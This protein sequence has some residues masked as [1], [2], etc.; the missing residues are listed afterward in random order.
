MRCLAQIASAAMLI[1]P[2]IAPADEADERPIPQDPGKQSQYYRDLLAWNR[3]TL[4][5][6]YEAVGRKDPRWD[7]PA[8]EALEAAARHFGQAVDP[9]TDEEAIFGPAKRAVDAGC[10]DPLIL[11][12]HARASTGP[13]DPG[14]EEARRR[15]DAAA[16]LEHSDYPPL[17]RILA[18]LRAGFARF[19]VA[20]AAPAEREAATRWLDSALA[21]IPAAVEKRDRDFDEGEKWCE[22][23]NDVYA[24]SRALTKDAP[25]AFERVDAGLARSP[26]LAVIRLQTRAKF[27]RTSAAI[28]GVWTIRGDSGQLRLAIGLF[29]AEPTLWTPSL[30][31][32]IPAT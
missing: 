26:A 22:A 8:G 5:G 6:A 28:L 1:A 14:P 18:M 2:A 30:A 21:L 11:Y 13:N 25:A 32:R 27:L 24:G 31:S 20:D 15:A 9:G 29:S 10:D 4:G 7:K 3:R 16:A 19:G 17:R 12:L 23:A